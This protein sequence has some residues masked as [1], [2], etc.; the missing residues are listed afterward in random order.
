MG[1]QQ[2]RSFAWLAGIVDGEGTVSVQCYTLPDGRVRLVPFVS[3]ANTDKGI[4]DECCEI[5]ARMG[6]KHQRLVIPNNSGGFQNSRKVFNIRVDG[7]KPVKV[8]LEA[9]QPFLR[10]VKREKAASVLKFIESRMLRGV[11]RNERGH[12]R[13]VEYSRAEVEMLSSVRC[14]SRA[15]SSET[16]C[17]APNVVG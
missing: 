3:I 13:R 8:V 17:R 1:N 5:L 11:E 10:S 6:V 4:L 9:L 2:E 15:K 7:Q 16:I 14:H 12:C